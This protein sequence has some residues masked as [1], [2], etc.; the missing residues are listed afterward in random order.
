MITQR[1]KRLNIKYH[2]RKLYYAPAWMVLGVN[3]LCNLHCKMCDVGTQYK[4]SNFYYNLMGSRPLNMPLELIKRIIDQTAR[5]F[6]KARLGYAFTEPLIYPHLTESIAYAQEKNLYKTIT[7][8]ALTLETKAADLAEAGLNE[9]FVSLDGPPEIHN[10]IRG[11]RRSFQKAFE[12]MEKIFSLPGRQ[13]QVSVFCTITEWNVGHLVEFIEMFLK[14]PLKQIGFMHTNFTP[15]TVAD[16]HNHI[17]GE[18][19]PATIS[20]MEE[21]SLANMD[22]EL[23]LEEIHQIKQT[24]YPFPIIVSPDLL[25]K[26]ETDIFYLQPERI[27]GSICN[28][29]FRTMMFKSDGTVIPA[30]GRCYNLTVG[31]IYEQSLDEI[32]NSK[33]LAQFRKTLIDAGGLLPACSRCCSAF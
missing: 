6:P 12:G 33:S 25:T 27:I 5:Y 30:H 20:N 21:I 18:T 10:F 23:L 17:Y 19:Y 22:L 7:T 15:N 1:L 16:F 11:N 32:W 26:E 2:P 3:N 14:M 31:N 4:N 24:N 9:V 8:N 29:A 28:D 13:P